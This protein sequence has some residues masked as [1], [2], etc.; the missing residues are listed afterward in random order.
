VQQRLRSL[1][2]LGADFDALYN[3]MESVRIELADVQQEIDHQMDRLES[4][5]SS[6]QDIDELLDRLYRLQTKHGV[7]TVDALM[8]IREELTDKITNTS[9]IDQRIAM[10]QSEQI[11]LTK[12]LNVAADDLHQ[13]RTAA[14][15]KF[16][17][18]VNEYLMQLSLADAQWQLRL[19][20][21]DGLNYYGG[22]Q[23]ALWFSANKG[24][25]PQ[26]IHLAVSGGEMSRVVLAVKA[27]LAEFKSLPTLIFDEIDTGISGEI[28]S[29]MAEILLNMSGR[30]QLFCMTH[31]PQTAAKGRFH[32]RIFKESDG[33]KT[34]TYIKDLGP[35]ERIQEIAQ[36]IG[37]RE[38]TD[39]AKAHARQLLN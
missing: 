13:K 2:H 25:A 34:R 19:K 38:L 33:E 15:P 24:I 21:I 29:K 14:V 3:R 7:D 5:P 9:T 27:V 22:A 37:G 4:D 26:L 39:S 28:A 20:R 31:L 12:Q 32:K 16:E 11:T 30:G 17:R 8:V 10:L 18:L 23:L 35:Q 6:L 36:M 1:S